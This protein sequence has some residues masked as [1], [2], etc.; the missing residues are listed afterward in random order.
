MK[1][2]E[3]DEKDQYL[4]VDTKKS[5]FRTWRTEG[6]LEE[7]L[8]YVKKQVKGKKKYVEYDKI[9]FRTEDFISAIIVTCEK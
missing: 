1:K 3:L 2:N 5:T 7:M 4:Q 6:C 9:C 8:E